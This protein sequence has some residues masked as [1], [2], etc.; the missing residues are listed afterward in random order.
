MDFPE[1]GYSGDESFFGGLM[2]S[3]PPVP[4]HLKPGRQAADT[5][6]GQSGGMMDD[7]EMGPETENEGQLEKDMSDE[8][9]I[10]HNKHLD[11]IEK[12]IGAEVGVETMAPRMGRR[13]KKKAHRPAV[14]LEEEVAGDGDQVHSSF[15]A[16]ID[17]LFQDDF[18]VNE[19]TDFDEG[20][21]GGDRIAQ[22]LGV[23]NVAVEDL[24]GLELSETGEGVNGDVGEDVVPSVKKRKMR[25]QL[26]GKNPKRG[27]VGDSDIGATVMAGEGDTAPPEDGPGPRTRRVFLRN[28]LKLRKKPK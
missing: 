21:N 10:K 14:E 2:G 8:E 5:E 16:E 27:K 20:Q 4:E 26:K 12:G 17:A 28:P 7:T 11:E 6:L 3:Y 15:E 25:K 18:A 24:A 22:D 13:L 19:F 23:E 9:I 1:H